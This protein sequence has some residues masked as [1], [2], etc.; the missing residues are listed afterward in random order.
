[1]R[2]IR[3]SDYKSKITEYDFNT[4]LM[5]EANPELFVFDCEIKAQETISL[6]LR[7]RY[8]LTELFATYSDY[9][10]GTTYNTGDTVWHSVDNTEFTTFLYAPVSATTSFDLN[11]WNIVEVRNALILDWMVTISLYRLHERLSPQNIPVHRKEAYDGVMSLL[12]NIQSEKLSPDF[13]ELEDRSYGIYI[14]GKEASGI[15]YMW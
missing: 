4:L 8:D 9:V 10:S 15:D 1:M 12:K 3:N 5:D 6:F 7:K 2:F 13:P 14:T 11:N